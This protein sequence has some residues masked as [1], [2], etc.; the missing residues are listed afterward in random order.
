M[1]Q[2][3]KK[4]KVDRGSITRPAS[5]LWFLNSVRRYQNLQKIPF[6]FLSEQKK[7]KQ[8]ALAH[9]APRLLWSLLDF[10]QI[11]ATSGKLIQNPGFC[12]TLDLANTTICCQKPQKII[13]K[14][15][16]ASFKLAKK[17]VLAVSTT[18][19][20]DSM[21]EFCYKWYFIRSQQDDLVPKHQTE[22]AHQSFPV[23]NVFLFHEF[24]RLDYDLFSKMNGFEIHFVEKKSTSR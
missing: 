18:L 12:L 21:L 11:H 19:R 8:E 9:D 15:A 14:K 22:T 23:T 13:S 3:N 24:D 20:N 17:T 16:V 2:V 5:Q 10:I 7:Q 1:T 6:L 4:F